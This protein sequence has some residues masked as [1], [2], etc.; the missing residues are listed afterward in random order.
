MIDKRK[1]K[2]V[3]KSNPIDTKTTNV[4]DARRGSRRASTLG[5]LNLGGIR[6]QNNLPTNLKPEDPGASNMRTAAPVTPLP[7]VNEFNIN[8]ADKI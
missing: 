4:T 5:G 3:K 2:P 7:E 6:Q 8:P 1:L